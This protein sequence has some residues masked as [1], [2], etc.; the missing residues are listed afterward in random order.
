MNYAVKMISRFSRSCLE[1]LFVIALF[2][3]VIFFLIL[4]L[5][6]VAIGRM[7]HFIAFFP[8]MLGSKIL[9]FLKAGIIK[10]SG[11]YK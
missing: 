7:I 10:I 1:W 11:W 3:V 4:A 6:L 8:S 2:T 9:D 5:F